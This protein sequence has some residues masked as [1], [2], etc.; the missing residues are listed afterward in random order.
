MD[1]G[2]KKYRNVENPTLRESEL[3]IAVMGTQVGHTFI[4]LAGKGNLE[5]I[6]YLRADRC[7]TAGYHLNPTAKNR[8]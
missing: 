1:K 7:G 6:Y 8:L 2:K 3:V 4:N 5:E